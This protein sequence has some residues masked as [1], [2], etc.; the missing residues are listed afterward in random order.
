MSSVKL[1]KVHNFFCPMMNKSVSMHF[2]CFQLCVSL[3]EKIADALTI[4]NLHK[5]L[6][7][8]LSLIKG[9]CFHLIN[10]FTQS[11]TMLARWNVVSNLT[12]TNVVNEK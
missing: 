7:V 2:V 4:F 3:F 5:N 10:I 12:G 6:L 9:N 8:F 11:K 1:L